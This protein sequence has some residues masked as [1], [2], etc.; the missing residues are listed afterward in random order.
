M[1]ALCQEL[2][3]DHTGQDCG[4]WSSASH[5]SPRLL[6]D[7]PGFMPSLREVPLDLD[8]FLLMLHSLSRLSR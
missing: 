3:L 7:G 1:A 8:P 4:S 2:C 6:A 5:G